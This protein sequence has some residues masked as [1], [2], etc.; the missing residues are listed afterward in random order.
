MFVELGEMFADDFEKDNVA[1]C[2]GLTAGKVAMSVLESCYKVLVSKKK[3]KKIEDLPRNEREIIW[4][5]AK[6]FANGRL[7]NNEQMITLCKSIYAVEYFL[8]LKK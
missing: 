6:E 3:I 4:N 7:K 8:T 2:N 5:T 1:F